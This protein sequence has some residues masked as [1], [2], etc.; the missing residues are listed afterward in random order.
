M[1]IVPYNYIDD[2]EKDEAVGIESMSITYIQPADT[3][4]DRDDVQSLKIELQYGASYD[5]EQF[6]QGKEGFYFDISLPE[7]GH[8]S[9]DSGEQLAAMIDDFKQRIYLNQ[10]DKHDIQESNQSS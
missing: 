4:S 1:K 3:C 9:V 6:E 2:L 7:G 8:W 5:R 10:L